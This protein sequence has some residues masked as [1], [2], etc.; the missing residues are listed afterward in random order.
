V[1]YL[2][3]IL[4]VN[5]MRI[6]MIWYLDWFNYLINE[7]VIYAMMVLVSWILYP[8]TQHLFSQDNLLDLNILPFLNMDDIQHN[9]QMAL[10]S[11]TEPPIDINELIVI[12]YPY[13]NETNTIPLALGILNKPKL[14][15]KIEVIDDPK[16]L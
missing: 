6:V 2:G 16:K 1:I 13:E 5:S 15:T 10:L 12:E 3:S 9:T 4:L 14:V 8:R 11:M 7:V